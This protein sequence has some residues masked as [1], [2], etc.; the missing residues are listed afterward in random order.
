MKTTDDWVK[1]LNLT[2]H[3]AGGYFRETYRSQE[4]MGKQGLYD[5]AVSAVFPRRFTFY[6]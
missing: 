1:K 5:L 4:T 2:V 3:P 6:L